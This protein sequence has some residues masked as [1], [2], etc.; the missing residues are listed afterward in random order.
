MRPFL[1]IAPYLW[2]PVTVGAGMGLFALLITE[3]APTVV[4]LYASIGLVGAAVLA[5]QWR[6]PERREWRP[7][8]NAVKTD[9]AFM[10]VIQ[11]ALPQALAAACALAL[12]ERLQRDLVVDSGWP[13][14]WP[15]AAQ[16]VLMLVLVDFMRYWLHRA[17]HRYSW[18]W[19]LHAVHHSPQVLYSLNSGR[20]HPLE[21]TLHF[22]VDTAPFLALGV[23]PEVIAGYVLLYAANGLFQHSNVRLRY[24]WLNYLV[25]SAETHRWHHARDPRLAA[26]NYGTTTAIW[27][28]LFGTW[29]LRGRRQLKEVGIMDAS[30]PSNVLEQ[31]LVP[32]GLK[33]GGIRAAVQRRVAD[34][35][36]RSHL[37]FTLLV[38]GWRITRA[39]RHPMRAQRALLARILR[40]NCETAFG[41]RHGFGVTMDYAAFARRVPVADYEALRPYIE[42]E[43]ERRSD[44][45][46]PAVRPASPRIF[47]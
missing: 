36:I 38:Q 12:S 2:Y 33:A 15:L 26:C 25:G 18:L 40:D 42:A 47:R 19:R 20:F 46:E 27:D 23:A 8:W 45:S 7:C 30:Y 1:R 43:I 16:V 31:I 28:V 6:F 41:R 13:H 21:K 39:A 10:A 32:L 35:L 44:T 4:A 14:A 34:L 9:L 24:G 3:A 5:L 22:C 17:C 11:G 29:A 37:G